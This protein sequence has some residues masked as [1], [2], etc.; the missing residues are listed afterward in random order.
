M[1][2]TLRQLIESIEEA[3]EDPQAKER[4]LTLD[5][6][7]C[8]ICGEPSEEN[9]VELAD[10]GGVEA[11]SISSGKTKHLFFFR[12]APQETGE[13]TPELAL[14]ELRRTARK[15]LGKDRADEIELQAKNDILLDLEPQGHA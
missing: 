10:I 2:I 8:F 6:E 5:S 14:T 12:F 1:N 15:F 13:L 4:G 9:R 3:V 7:I 11:T